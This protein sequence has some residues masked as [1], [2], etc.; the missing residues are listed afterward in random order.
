MPPQLPEACDRGDDWTGLASAAERRRRQNRLSQRTYRKKR[1]QKRLAL[2]EAS[3]PGPE[4][5]DPTAGD[6][7]A[8]SSR[9]EQ[10]ATAPGHLEVPDTPLNALPIFLLVRNSPRLHDDVLQFLQKATA[11]W[12]INLP[13]ARDLPGLS[14]LNAFDAL[15]RNAQLLHIPYEFLKSDKFSSLFNYHGPEPPSTAQLLPASLHPTSLQRKV[16]HQSWLDLFPF[17]GLRDN[18]LRGFQEKRLNEEHLRYELCC[19][20]VNFETESVSLLLVWGDSW[21]ARGWE[22]TPAFFQKWGFLLQGCP[23]A[24]QT[25]N[26]WREKR[27]AMKIDIELN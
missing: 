12:S 7:C 23:E 5:A 26:Y 18:V 9:V 20:L 24:L 10:A 15:A 8:L 4:A 27:G 21:D 25:T 13:V 1:H 6:V 16:T 2:N 3:E 17:P 22:F 14:R 19:D 11:H